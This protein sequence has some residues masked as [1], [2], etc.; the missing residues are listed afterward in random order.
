MSGLPFE[1]C[2][3]FCPVVVPDR[4][5]SVS[6]NYFPSLDYVDFVL[7]DYIGFVYPQELSCREHFLY[8]F[9]AHQG[10]YRIFL[11][12]DMDF[13]VVLQGFHIEDFSGFDAYKAVS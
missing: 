10:E 5:G 3:K 6:E 1:E 7:V 9:H 2:R 13:H 11:A 4:D 12:F 8:R